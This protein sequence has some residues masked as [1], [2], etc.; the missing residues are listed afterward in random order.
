MTLNGDCEYIT[1][2]RLRD[3]GALL[4]RQTFGERELGALATGIAG[5]LS[6]PSCAIVLLPKEEG[7]CEEIVGFFP[8]EVGMLESTRTTTAKFYGVIARRVSAAGIPL[9]LPDVEDMPPSAMG[10]WLG[11][12]EGVPLFIGGIAAGAILVPLGEGRRR[13]VARESE[14]LA[15]IALGVGKS[16]EVARLRNLLQSRFAQLALV[17]DGKKLLEFP[18]NLQHLESERFV[19]IFAKTFYREMTQAGFD[20]AHIIKA[21]TEIISLLGEKVGRLSKRQSR[22]E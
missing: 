3:F 2:G 11:G 22:Y 6:T 18:L 17:R 12:V 9:S 4:E 8:N 16:V 14:L 7:C 5:V 20:N 19:K 10:T 21:A 1:T 15:A 13:L